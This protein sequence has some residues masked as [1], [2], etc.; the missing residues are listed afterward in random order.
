MVSET[1]ARKMVKMFRDAGW[2]AG[3]TV[4]SH[5]KWHCPC[6]Q[7]TFTLPDGHRTISPGV[8]RNALKT[9]KECS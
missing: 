1:P 8:T 7:H 3:R 5:T 9:L 2:T 4:G 6:G